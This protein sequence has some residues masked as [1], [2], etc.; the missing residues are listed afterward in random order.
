MGHKQK[1]EKAEGAAGPGRITR[2]LIEKWNQVTA[3]RFQTG[4]RHQKRSVSLRAVL[5]HSMHTTPSHIYSRPDMTFVVDWALSNNYLSI[6][7]IYLHYCFCSSKICFSFLFAF[8]YIVD[9]QGLLALQKFPI[10]DDDDD[11]DDDDHD[12]DDD[13]DDIVIITII[14]PFIFHLVHFPPIDSFV[15]P[16]VHIVHSVQCVCGKQANMCGSMKTLF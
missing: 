2:Q 3:L 9:C 13:A 14:L 1:K 8:V 5:I 7:L 15:V 16:Y 6:Y 11:D 12:D 10:H 4:R